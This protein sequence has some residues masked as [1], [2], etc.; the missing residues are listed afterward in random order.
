MNLPVWQVTN[1]IPLTPD[2]A[3]LAATSY[4]RTRH[5]EISTWDV[6]D[7][8]L[9]KEFCTANTWIY[10]VSLKDPQSGTLEYGIKVLMD[11]SIWKPTKEKRH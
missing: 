6:D 8:E 3:V 4:S 2:K 7:I 10:N 11:G 1:A 5:P 9:Q